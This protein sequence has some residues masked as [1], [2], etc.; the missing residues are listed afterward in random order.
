MI[1]RRQF[2]CT[3]FLALG[4]FLSLSPFTLALA[5][6]NNSSQQSQSSNQEQPNANLTPGEEARTRSIALARYWLL[7]QAAK[8][9]GEFPLDSMAGD[10]DYT[11]FFPIGRSDRMYLVLINP[12]PP[13]GNEGDYL[14]LCYQR[15]GDKA[16]LVYRIKIASRYRV[17]PSGKA[18]DTNVAYDSLLDYITQPTTYGSGTEDTKRVTSY[19]LPRTTSAFARKDLATKRDYVQYSYEPVI[20]TLEVWLLSDYQN[21]HQT[22]DESQIAFYGLDP[23]PF[24][25][26]PLKD[27]QFYKKHGLPVAKQELPL[28]GASNRSSVANMPGKGSAS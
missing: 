13:L 6:D 2:N 18:A 12:Y 19:F 17:V 1:A 23:D 20:G 9:L 24:T 5:Q 4:L 25:N 10:H 11:A 26:A 28:I 21:V 7:N 14:V 27:D 15:N 3:V 22:P 8:K 16:K